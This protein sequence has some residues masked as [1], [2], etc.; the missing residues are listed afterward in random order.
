MLSGVAL[1]T[2]SLTTSVLVMR[3]ARRLLLFI[4]F[5]NSNCDLLV[6]LSLPLRLRCFTGYHL[7][8]SMLSG[9]GWLAGWLVGWLGWSAGWLV[10]W[11]VG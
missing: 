7:S 3:G 10:G 2:I 11:L 5:S 6:A 4:R 9:V 1:A 8:D